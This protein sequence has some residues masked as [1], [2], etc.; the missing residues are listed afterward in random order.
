MLHRPQ[1]SGWIDQLLR[2]FNFL[3]CQPD[4]GGQDAQKTK[5]RASG[6]LK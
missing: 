6:E 4:I 3:R 1:C 2:L 5:I